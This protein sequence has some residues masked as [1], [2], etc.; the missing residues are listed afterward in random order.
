M[1]CTRMWKSLVAGKSTIK[2]R[3]YLLAIGAIEKTIAQMLLVL[4]WLHIIIAM[5]NRN[6]IHL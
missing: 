2:V 5:V 4:K 6:L 3:A 1:R